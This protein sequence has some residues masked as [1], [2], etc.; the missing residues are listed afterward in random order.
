MGI[1]S[2]AEDLPL[3]HIPFPNEY[4]TSNIMPMG[5]HLTIE[6]LACN[7]TPVTEAGTYVR[8]IL[9]EAVVPFTGCQNGPGFSCALANYTELVSAS[10]PDFTSTCGF[11][12][13][14]PQ[15]LSFFWDY[16]TTNAFNYETQPYIPSREKQLTYQG[17]A[18]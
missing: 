6:R 18:A 10:L 5:G 3:D 11:N 17:T 16:N 2:P 4:S 12:E 15:H 9:N 13:S 14:Y 8:L 1:S 7:A